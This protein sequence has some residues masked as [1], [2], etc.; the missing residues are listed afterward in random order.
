MVSS[1]CRSYEVEVFQL[2][3]PKPSKS[4]RFLALQLI[5]PAPLNGPVK[6]ATRHWHQ[7]FNSKQFPSLNELST[8]SN[9]FLNVCKDLMIQ[10]ASQPSYP[11][12]RCHA[13]VVR[14]GPARSQTLLPYASSPKSSSSNSSTTSPPPCSSSSL[15][16]LP[17]NHPNSTC[18]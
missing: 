13:N 7:S 11:A 12:G 10:P 6:A 9:S 4:H 15:P 8:I 17:A 2:S 14:H 18:S 5:D 3:F 16:S 1:E